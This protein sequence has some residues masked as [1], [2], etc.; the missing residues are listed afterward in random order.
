MI[1]VAFVD[2]AQW[3]IP[4]VENY[5]KEL[6]E[7]RVW[8]PNQTFFGE[9]DIVF[10]SDGKRGEN[11]FFKKSKLVFVTCEDLFPDFSKAHFVVSCR[12]V[13][14][15]RYLRMP[16]W[17]IIND[18]K[19]LIKLPGYADE[20]LSQSRQFCAFV[21]SNSNPRRTR[22]RLDFFSALSSRRFVHSGGGTLNNIGYRV[23]NIHKFLE[24][25]KLYICFENAKSEGYTTEKIVNAMLN[26]CI[27]I[28]WGDPLIHL[29][30]NTCSFI[31]VT[32]FHSES[33][34]LDHVEQ[35]A[36]DEILRKNYLEQPFF[37]GNKIPPL[38]ERS[39]II[40]FFKKV[41]DE[42]RPNKIF[43]SFRANVEKIRH[44]LR[45]YVSRQG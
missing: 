10:F 24:C 18:P 25:F 21:Q 38:F 37:H 13:E 17:A 28:Y 32:Q 8:E 34:L 11:R 43:F 9:P 20:I 4:F 2:D 14:H 19:I 7:Y 27:P 33:D 45:P 16:Y 23:E 30:F 31:D 42:P 3:A 12:Y 6:V 39:R 41:L 44:R 35:V 40:S 15:E 29:D 1:S 26:G 5:L 22:R 36:D